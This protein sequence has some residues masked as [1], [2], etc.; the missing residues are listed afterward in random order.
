MS[1]ISIA[2]YIVALI[3]TEI[4][5]IWLMYVDQFFNRCIHT[6][7]KNLPNPKFV[8]TSKV[9]NL[10]TFYDPGDLENEVEVKLMRAIKFCH[11]APQI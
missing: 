5:L 3:L 2:R 7:D 11:C 6:Y 4:K 1:W 8:P 9:Q 10:K